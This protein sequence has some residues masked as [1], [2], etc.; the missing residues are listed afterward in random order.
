MELCKDFFLVAVGKRLNYL[1]FSTFLSIPSDHILFP[2]TSV[3]SL[4]PLTILGNNMCGLYSASVKQHILSKP[5]GWARWLWFA[6]LVIGGGR[7][8]APCKQ[9]LQDASEFA[10]LWLPWPMRTEI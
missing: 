7:K 6:S 3:L 8:L 1:S 2:C 5:E 9:G 4:P 10:V